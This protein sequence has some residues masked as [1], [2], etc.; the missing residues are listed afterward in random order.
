MILKDDPAHVRRI[1]QP[2]RRRH[3]TEACLTDAGSRQQGNMVAKQR[4][5]NGRSRADRTIAADLD[6]WADHGIRANPRA[7]TDGRP[8]TDHRTG[9]N[10]RIVVD[11]CGRVDPLLAGPIHVT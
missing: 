8:R 5:E 10:D 7:F 6:P 1:A 2:L 3:H 4:A 11:P 9:C